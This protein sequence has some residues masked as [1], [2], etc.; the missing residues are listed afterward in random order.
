MKHPSH[1]SRT[2]FDPLGFV[3][4][5]AVVAKILLQ[6][7]CDEIAF[8]IAEWFEVV[9]QLKHLNTMKSARF[10]RAIE[11]VVWILHSQMHQW[12]PKDV[13]VPRN[14]Q[15]TCCGGKI[16]KYSKYPKK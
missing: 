14:W 8:R 12:E 4:P 3:I 1:S 11:P 6:G 10:L 13:Q 16:S 15:R 9:N 2:I 5:F 7:L